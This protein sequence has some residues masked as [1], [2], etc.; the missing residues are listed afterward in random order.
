MSARA[1]LSRAG[2]LAAIGAL[3]G[4]APE[5]SPWTPALLGQRSPAMI[6]HLVGA[7]PGPL[8]ELTLGTWRSP[9][10]AARRVDPGSLHCYA[11]GARFSVSFDWRGR[12]DRIELP[13]VAGECAAEAL[14][15]RAIAPIL[16][17]E[18]RGA[19]RASIHA[20]ADMRE[21]AGRSVGT[22][23]GSGG[24]LSV[25]RPSQDDPD[26]RTMSWTLEV[27]RH[28][29]APDGSPVTRETPFGR[30][31]PLGIA[32]WLAAC[33]APLARWTTDASDPAAELWTNERRAPSPERWHV[34]RRP[35]GSQVLECAEARRP[36][37]Q[38]IGWRV[39]ADRR[40][41]IYRIVVMEA[42]G[43]ALGARAAAVAE[44]LLPG[45]LR[46]EAAASIAGDPP[47]RPPVDEETG[48]LAMQVS[49][50]SEPG[51]GAELAWWVPPWL[52]PERDL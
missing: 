30:L 34:L 4:C 39:E 27:P 15:D 40:D 46:A 7:C 45:A 42:D 8:E 44:A 1:I 17:A 11:S 2:A 14:F 29:A 10:G 5:P 43:E 12:V 21:L 13:D 16:A 20:T 23:D 49:R 28:E 25:V 38:P 52:L 50:A 9:I 47:F 35:P 3:G 6:A 18:L 37:G 32:A 51:W 31:S 22:V 36:G 41:R 48:A 19:I 26:A 24:R 33:A